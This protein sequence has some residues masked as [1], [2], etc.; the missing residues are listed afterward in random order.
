M[1]DPPTPIP[2]QENIDYFDNPVLKAS[3]LTFYF[4]VRGSSCELTQRTLGQSQASATFSLGLYI[5]SWYIGCID[6]L[7]IWYISY[8]SF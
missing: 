8:H 2:A 1:L 6:N 4:Y 3:E 5:V 7:A